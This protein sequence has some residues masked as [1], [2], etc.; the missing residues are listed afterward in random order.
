MKEKVEKKKQAENNNDIQFIE[1]RWV[2]FTFCQ[3]YSGLLQNKVHT[4]AFK[5]I[6]L[7]HRSPK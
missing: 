7:Q 3:V 1:E 6:E 2:S 4:A 5:F